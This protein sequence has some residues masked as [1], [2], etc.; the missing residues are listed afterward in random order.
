MEQEPRKIRLWNGEP[1]RRLE[2]ET[3]AERRYGCAG[4]ALPAGDPRAHSAARDKVIGP[5]RPCRHTVICAHHGWPGIDPGERVKFRLLRPRQPCLRLF[6]ARLA[7]PVALASSRQAEVADASTHHLCVRR[8]AHPAE[9]VGSGC[10]RCDSGRAD[11]GRPQLSWHF[12]PLARAE[13]IADHARLLAI[14]LLRIPNHVAHVRSAR[15]LARFHLHLRDTRGQ[16]PAGGDGADPGARR[17]AVGADPRLSVFHRDLLPRPL[18]RQHFGRGTGGD[19]RHLHQPGLEYGLFLLPVAAH[20]TARSRRSRPRLPAH[21]LAEVLAARSAVRDAGADLEHHD[22][23]VGRLVLRRRLG[24]DNGRRHDHRATWSRLLHRQGERRRQLVGDRRGGADDG[25][26]HPP[27][28]PVAIPPDR[29][30][31]GEVQGRA[32]GQSGRRVRPGCST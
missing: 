9:P 24:S 25:D 12:G 6:S 18:P 29:R 11:G 28:R 5:R 20:R 8:A 1:Y 13:R 17:P 30:L 22:V 31:G 23:D 21:R 2:A 7:A 32:L 15:R 26:R 16:E 3:Q 4:S 10:V 19:L 27:V 14:A